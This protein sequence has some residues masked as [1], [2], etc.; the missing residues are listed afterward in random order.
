MQTRLLPPDPDAMQYAASLLKEGGLVAFPTETVY[1]LGA[2]ALDEQA[3]L[4]IFAAKERPA[5]NPLIVH[6]SQMD[7]LPALC[8][9]NDKAKR[10]MDAFWPGP[11][12]LLLPKTEAV[13][14]VVTAGLPTVAVRMP[15]HPVAKALLDACRCPVAAPSANRSGR[16]SPTLAEHVLEDMAGRIP[17][18]LDGGPCSVG[19]ESTVVDMTRDIPLVLRPG[20]VTPQMLTQVIGPIETDSSVLKPLAPGETAPSPGMRHRHYA[21]RG[22]LTLVSGK[23]ENVCAAIVKLYDEAAAQEKSTCILSCSEHVS[24][25]GSRYVLDIGSLNHPEEVGV[26]L[27]DL[28]RRMD[29][30]GIV[31]IFSEVVEANGL[32]LAIMNRLN[33]AASFRIIDADK[34]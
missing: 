12:T 34:A 32:G 13:P 4:S 26:R 24:K 28:L 2:N 21:P 25:Y 27:F 33:R 3:V 29:R 7:D 17:L 30:E 6:I 1:G 31:C 9:V 22:V 18:I 15:S 10:L 5:D 20:G 23:P 14:S 11:L 19:L 8:R 16:P